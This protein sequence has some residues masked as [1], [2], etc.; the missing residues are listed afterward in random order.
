M[1]TPSEQK[2]LAFVAIVIL[3]GGQSASSAPDPQL[4]PPH[5]S[6]RPS[7]ARRQ[8][9]TAPPEARRRRSPHDEG[10]PLR[11]PETLMSLPESRAFLL[12]SPDRTVPSIIRRTDPVA[13]DS[14][15]PPPSPASTQ[16]HMA[17]GDNSICDRFS[18]GTPRQA[19]RPRRGH[20]AGDRDAPENRTRARGPNRRESG[21]SR[22]IRLSRRT[23]AREGDGT[24]IPRP[25][26]AAR[27]LRRPVRL[28]R[29]RVVTSPSEVSTALFLHLYR[30][31]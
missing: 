4:R 14:A 3:L 20:R 30:E 18:E 26:G 28:Q 17:H 12:P 11:H 24:G 1:P 27:H 9:P 23:Q 15:F 8:P 19:H 13:L 31:S 7:S 6:N 21:F 5:T 29:P 2:A 25:S 16:T 10:E 22:T